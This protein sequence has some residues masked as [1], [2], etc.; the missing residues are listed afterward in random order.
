MRFLIQI[1]LILLLQS[2]GVKVTT[3]SGSGGNSF[4]STV[5]QS[6]QSCLAQ[7]QQITIPQANRNSRTA[8]FV[9]KAKNKRYAQGGFTGPGATCAQ[10]RHEYRPELIFG[11]ILVVYRNGTQLELPSINR[12]ANQGYNEL[13]DVGSWQTLRLRKANVDLTITDPPHSHPTGYSR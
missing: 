10:V 8:T 6:Y 11:Y 12:I 3:T 9:L 2:C 4:R 1:L 5:E 13:G 7:L